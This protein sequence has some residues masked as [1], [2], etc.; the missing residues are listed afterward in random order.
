VD[1]F[2]EVIVEISQAEVEA[3]ARSLVA[4]GCTAIAICFL[5]SFRNDAA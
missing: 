1:C 4:D 3:A 2:G 5:W